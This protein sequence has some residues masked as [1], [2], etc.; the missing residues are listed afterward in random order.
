MI[1]EFFLICWYKVTHHILCELLY[2]IL[3]GCFNGKGEV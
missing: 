3:G 1:L 2:E